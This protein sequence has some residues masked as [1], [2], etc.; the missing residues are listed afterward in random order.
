MHRSSTEILTEVT[1]RCVILSPD[2]FLYLP[3]VSQTFCQHG[4][5][6][7]RMCENKFNEFHD[8]FKRIK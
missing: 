4:T 8:A 2:S 6:Q 3:H 1:E 7:S 5:K